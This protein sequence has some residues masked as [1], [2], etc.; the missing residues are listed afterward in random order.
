[1]NDKFPSLT[2]P[3]THSTLFLKKKC[4]KQFLLCFYIRLKIRL[5][6]IESLLIILGK[7][8]IGKSENH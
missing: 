7:M 1:M 8:R 3:Y 4:H 5:I 2:P 6:K